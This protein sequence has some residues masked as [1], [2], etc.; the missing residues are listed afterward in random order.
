MSGFRGQ[1]KEFGFASKAKQECFLFCKRISPLS[2][3]LVIA[4]VFLFCSLGFYSE[5]P[6]DKLPLSL[7]VEGRT[8]NGWGPHS[9]VDHLGQVLSDVSWA[10]ARA[11]G[12]D[13]F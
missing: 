10:R 11:P 9:A 2:M 12:H 3:S 13:S 6:M 8:L 7:L 1:D 5:G 4:Y